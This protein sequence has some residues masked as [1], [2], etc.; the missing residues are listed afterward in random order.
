MFD[1]KAAR[2]VAERLWPS[3]D[4]PN[5]ET[6]IAEEVERLRLEY[7]RWEVARMVQDGTLSPADGWE[8]MLAA[9]GCPLEAKWAWRAR[10]LPCVFN[11]KWSTPEEIA[12]WAATLEV[13]RSGKMIKVYHD[14]KMLGKAGGNRAARAAAV[15]V[16]VTPHPVS[17]AFA[18][19]V[20]CRQTVESAH[21]A[22][23]RWAGVIV[24]PS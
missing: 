19:E 8:A 9:G 18:V 17:G 6:R 11:G 20:S 7:R 4:N 12:A 21:K 15:I 14:G 24:V 2:Q 5:R 10:Y 16:T 1:E 13:V 22:A 23:G 3:L